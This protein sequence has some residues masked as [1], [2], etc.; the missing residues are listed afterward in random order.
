MEQ[1]ERDSGLID[2]ELIK[3]RFGKALESYRQHA[4][5]QGRVNERLIALLKDNAEQSRFN[6][7]LEIGC[8]PGGL[9]KRLLEE[10]AVDE[11]HLNDIC[12]EWEEV[13]RHELG[14][15]FHT[16]HGC[17]GENFP[18]QGRFNLLLSASTVQWFHRPDRFF[19]TAAAHQSTGDVLLFSMFGCQNFNE[20]RTVT[21][22]GLTYPDAGQLKEWLKNDYDVRFYEEELI[23]L[24]FNSPIEVLRH[25]KNTG[26][27][28]T[29]AA[30]WGKKDLEAFCS[31]Y[32]AL[33]VENGEVKLT[34]HPVYV[35]AT[36][37]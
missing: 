18:F 31:R 30:F 37:K 3:R 14:G 26:V 24:R 33:F 1:M 34:Y 11:L 12:G 5:V 28:A 20:I 25:M 32:N 8:G 19:E 2:K 4:T 10:F 35:Y 23:S 27:T 21:G 17:D 6:R 15:L 29:G 13:L 16:F 22:I 36:K 9:A 7:A